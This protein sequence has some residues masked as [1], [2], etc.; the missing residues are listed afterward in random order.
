MEEGGGGGGGG[1]YILSL[2]PF[3]PDAWTGRE[4]WNV[5]SLPAI[6]NVPLH[7]LTVGTFG[8]LTT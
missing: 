7:A 8:G 3:C 2:L 6:P 5:Y 1:G 4:E